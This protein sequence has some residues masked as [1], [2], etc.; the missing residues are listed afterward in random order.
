MLIDT[1]MKSHRKKIEEQL[2]R[3]GCRPGNLKII[4]LTHGDMDHTG[5]APYLREKFQ[6]RIAMHRD[7]AGAV[8]HGQLARN[9]KIIGRLLMRLMIKTMFKIPRF[10]P[11]LLVDDGYNL[12]DFG[13]DTEILHIPGHTRGSIGILAADGDLFCGD[14]LANRKQ[15]AIGPIVDDPETLRKSV[16]RLKDLHIRT[17]YPGHGKPFPMSALVHS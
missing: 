1:G 13:F 8:E 5:N 4:V 17:V 12:A 14:I 2:A 11:D 16:D 7:D 6:T 10:K 9:Q 3:A 15:P